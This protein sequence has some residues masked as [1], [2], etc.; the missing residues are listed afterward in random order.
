MTVLGLRII[1]ILFTLDDIPDETQG[2]SETKQGQQGLHH[3][4]FLAAKAAAR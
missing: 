1:N 2:D 4:C 3:V